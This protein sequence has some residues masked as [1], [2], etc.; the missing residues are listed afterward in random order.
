MCGVLHRILAAG[1][2]AVLGKGGVPP[3]VA[4]PLLALIIILELLNY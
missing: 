3:P 4:F 1:G 2:S